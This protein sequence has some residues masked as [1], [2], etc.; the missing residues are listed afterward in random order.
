[1]NSRERVLAALR[2][3]EADMVPIDFGAM[4]STGISALAYPKLKKYLG[5][6]GGATIIYD[7]MQQLALPEDEVRERMGG[8]V[9]QLHRLCPSFTVPITEWK[10]STMKDGTPCL[11]PKEFNPVT[12]ENG[13]LIMYDNGIPV[14]R[15]PKDGYYFD[16]I[17][18]P[19]KDAETEADIDKLQLSL[20]SDEEVAF[21][22][23]EVKKLKE[24][25]CAILGA[26]GGNLFETGHGHFGFENFMVKMMTDRDLIE[27]YLDKITENHIAN[28]KIYLDAVGDDI[29]VIQMGDDLGM[30]SAPLLSPKLYKELFKP[31]HEKIFRYVKEHSNVYVFLHSCGSI[32]DLIPDLI[33]AG[34]D[35]LNPV[36]TSAVGMDPVKLKR[37][38]GKHLTFWGGGCDTQTTLTNGS[39]ADV[40]REVE[41]RIRIFA[42]GGGFVFTQVHNIQANI[43][44]EKIVAIY[45]TAKKFRI[46]PIK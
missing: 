32:I 15:M 44:P 22:K 40:V 17:Y 38:F 36:Q 14:A 16:N 33:E 5:I 3:E 45:D 37:E 26:F 19:L 21:L 9:V 10:E 39:V 41:E 4:R 27:Y 43:P 1:M 25:G 29:D 11:V 46:Y 28:L 7:L 24:T 23:R 13:D 35:I 6:E 8:D 2:H 34:V 20:I 31:R 18:Y 12:D 42:P 30:Q